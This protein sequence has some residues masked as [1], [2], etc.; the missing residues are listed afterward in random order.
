MAISRLLL[1]SLLAT[2]CVAQ[3]AAQSSVSNPVLSASE[4][5]FVSLSNSPT[6][7]NTDSSSSTLF[8][9]QA[10]S[11]ANPFSAANSLDEF[12]LHFNSTTQTMS[13][14]GEKTEVLFGP[15]FHM[16]K[17]NPEDMRNDNACL[18]LRTYRVVRDDPHSDT[19]RVA[20]YSTCQP[21][22]QYRV[23]TAVQSIEIKSRRPADE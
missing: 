22:A 1:I 19:T 11:A 17:P 5:D 20:G 8:Q 10:S 12:K 21:A 4:S 2:A 15:S 7:T 13:A 18:T 14:P 16:R 6:F 9:A 3:V 23:K